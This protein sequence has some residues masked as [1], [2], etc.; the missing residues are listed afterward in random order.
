MKLPIGMGAQTT[1]KE[2]MIV[3]KSS[4]GIRESTKAVVG[5]ITARYL[6][7][8]IRNIATSRGKGKK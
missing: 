3:G 8:K 4:I 5:V 7:L 6:Q 2:F 1:V